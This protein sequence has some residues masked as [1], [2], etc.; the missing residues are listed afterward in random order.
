MD[1]RGDEMKDD[2]EGAVGKSYGYEVYRAQTEE[3]DV[4]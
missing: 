1:V 2:F 3:F 4:S